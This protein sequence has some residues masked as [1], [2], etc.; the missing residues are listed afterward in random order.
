M[1]H[2]VGSS[3]TQFW[4]YISNYLWGFYIL[5]LKNLCYFLYFSRLSKR[6][7]ACCSGWV[8]ATLN[9]VF[10]LNF[11]LYCG[12]LGS[13]LT[14][15]SL[16]IKISS[17]EN[18]HRFYSFHH[19]YSID[20]NTFHSM[21][22]NILFKTKSDKMS[23]FYDEDSVA[24]NIMNSIECLAGFFF[25]RLFS[26]GFV[27]IADITIRISTGGSL[28]SRSSIILYPFHLLLSSKQFS[29]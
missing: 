24:S 9:S 23:I 8:A 20:F 28:D 1:L 18:K 11:Y 19:V 6:A 3:D 26:E 12:V 15:I 21:N 25:F 7:S 4:G 14:C 22:F 29:D 17:H 5:V 2:R 16:E 10:M 13:N 27:I